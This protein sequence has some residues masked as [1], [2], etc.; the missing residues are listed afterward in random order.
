MHPIQ[1]N[2]SHKAWG[3]LKSLLDRDNNNLKQKQCEFLV[4]NQLTTVNNNIANASND[5][6]VNVGK[7]LS[8]NIV[9]NVDPLSHVNIC[10]RGWLIITTITDARSFL[11]GMEAITKH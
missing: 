2:I 9:I 3:I 4:N 7:Y 8:A 11:H 10:I 1:G 5:Y 6:F